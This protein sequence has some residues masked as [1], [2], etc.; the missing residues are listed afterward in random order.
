VANYE[1]VYPLNDDQL[2]DFA[3]LDTFDMLSPAYDRPQT[4]QT[5]RSWLT[6]AG[7]EDIQVSKVNHLVGR[8]RKN[9]V[10]GP[11][12]GRAALAEDAACV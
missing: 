3:V 9:P 11:Q 7:L 2:L 6:K 12:P 10:E 1:G 8:G 5:L 4:P